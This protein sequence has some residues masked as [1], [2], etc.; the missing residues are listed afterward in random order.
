MTPR[1]FA[2][3]S[4]RLQAEIS[5]TALTLQLEPMLQA[6][7]ADPTG[8]ALR[9]LRPRQD[10]YAKAFVEAAEP[11]ARERYEQL[12]DTGIGFQRPVGRTRIAIHL[13]PAGALT[14]DNAMSRPFPGGYRSV[15]G[16]LTPTRVWATWQYRS[17]GSNTGLSYNGLTWCDDHWA[18]FPKPYR[19]LTR[20]RE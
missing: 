19:V 11:L 12:W 15:A 13:A 4:P 2:E 20:L 18:F 6:I 10:D 8:E 1:S 5:M 16:L 7:A 14:D 3:D 9:E 17:P